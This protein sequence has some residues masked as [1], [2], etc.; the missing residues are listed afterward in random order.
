MNKINQSN[1]K[2]KYEQKE[3]EKHI[4]SEGNQSKPIKCE[5]CNVAFPRTNYLK[6]HNTKH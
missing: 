5:I 2:V 4:T 3:S 1:L 6:A